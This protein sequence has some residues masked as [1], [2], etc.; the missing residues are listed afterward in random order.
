MQRAGVL[1]IAD[2]IQTGCGR[3]GAFTM[4]GEQGV[5]PDLLCLGKGLAG[6]IPV[7]VTAVSG[8]FIGAITRGSHT[9]T[10]GGNPVADSG[11]PGL[12]EV[13]TDTLLSA[14][15][16]NGAWFRQELEALAGSARGRGC[17]LGIP[18]GDRRGRGAERAA[19]GGRHCHSGGKDVVRFLPPLTIARSELA[20]AL[21]V[22]G[23]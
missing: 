13:I 11:C 14:V 8:A 10:F 3:T 19:A 15:R 7:G 23:T 9:S 21:E 22:L 1:L 6:G 5:Q 2:E 20:L 16:A 17:M 12:F 18:A 4:C